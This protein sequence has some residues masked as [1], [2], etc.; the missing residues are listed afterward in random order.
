M[1]HST[2]KTLADLKEDYSRN[3]IPRNLIGIFLLDLIIPK[4]PPLPLFTT[5]PPYDPVL[6]SAIKTL[7][8]LQ[9]YVLVLSIHEWETS[10]T[11]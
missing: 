5:N 7:M 2:R 3:D 4:P 9:D 8:S 6:Y 1:I 10:G 11:G